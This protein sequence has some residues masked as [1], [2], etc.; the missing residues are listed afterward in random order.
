MTDKDVR[1]GYDPRIKK[2]Y[3]LIK[4]RSELLEEVEEKDKKIKF[5]QTEINRLNEVVSNY[6]WQQEY[7]RTMF[8]DAFHMKEQGW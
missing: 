1:S 2:Y 7:D 8:Y 6:G 3:E 4:E 5:L